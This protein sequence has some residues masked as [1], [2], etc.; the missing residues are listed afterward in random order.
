MKSVKSCQLIVGVN[1]REV[2]RI[3]DHLISSCCIVANN[4]PCGLEL[5]TAVA[6]QLVQVVPALPDVGTTCPLFLQCAVLSVLG[7]DTEA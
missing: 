2:N 1:T 3:V 4:C 7:Q 6:H 5:W